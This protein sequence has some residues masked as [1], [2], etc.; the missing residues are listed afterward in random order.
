MRYKQKGQKCNNATRRA[1]KTLP[2]NQRNRIQAQ[3]KKGLWV[4]FRAVLSLLGPSKMGKTSLTEFAI[5]EEEEIV[6]EKLTSGEVRTHANKVDQ[7][8]SL[9]P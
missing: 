3:D 9:A 1:R 5:K 6:K 4:I 7:N 2:E 8:L